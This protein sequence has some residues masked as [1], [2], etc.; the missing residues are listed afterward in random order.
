MILCLIFRGRLELRNFYEASCLYVWSPHT[1]EVHLEGYR[2]GG[3][4]PTPRAAPELRKAF[5]PPSA[6][7]AV[8]HRVD[9]GIPGE[10]QFFQLLP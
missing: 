2:W 7:R 1:G 3:W 6:V 4:G 9:E 8:I 10:D 5:Q